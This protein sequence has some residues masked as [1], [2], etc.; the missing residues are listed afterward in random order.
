MKNSSEEDICSVARCKREPALR[1]LGRLLCDRHWQKLCAAEERQFVPCGELR[2]LLDA[3]CSGR[4]LV[5]N[6]SPRRLERQEDIGPLFAS[7][8]TEH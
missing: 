6:K 2:S 7:R 8:N 5:L 4:K 3:I 1:Y